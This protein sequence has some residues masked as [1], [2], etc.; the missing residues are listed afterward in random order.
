MVIL[1]LELWLL[2]LVQRQELR[3]QVTETREDNTSA[4]LLVGGVAVN[5]S[6]WD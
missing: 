3:V 5:W 4:G 1:S 6:Q 2:Q